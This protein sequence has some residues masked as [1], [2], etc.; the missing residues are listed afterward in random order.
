MILVVGSESDVAGILT[1]DQD[2]ACAAQILCEKPALR[3]CAEQ[4][5]KARKIAFVNRAVVVA[6]IQKRLEFAFRHFPAR[7]RSEFYPLY[8]SVY[9]WR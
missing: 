9:P 2:F 4:G 3:L 8:E 7:L 1:D 5:F 6:G